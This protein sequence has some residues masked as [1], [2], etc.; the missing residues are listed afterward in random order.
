M[1]GDIFVI[2]IEGNM[3]G[4][5]ES[6]NDSDDYRDDVKELL[7]LPDTHICDVWAHNFEEEMK[8]LSKM[9][10]RFNVIAMVELKPFRIPSFQAST[11]AGMKSTDIGQKRKQSIFSSARMWRK[12]NSFKSASPSQMKMAMSLTQFAPGSSILNST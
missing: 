9:T 4:R 3:Y 7:H 5:S 11:S 10:E 2:M 6:D 8:R 12:L 1:L